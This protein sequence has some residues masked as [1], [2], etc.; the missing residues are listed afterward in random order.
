MERLHRP[1]CQPLLDIG[2]AL[3]G[4]PMLII[5][6]HGRIFEHLLPLIALQEEQGK[7]Y[8]RDEED[9]IDGHIGVDAKCCRRVYFD[10]GNP[11][12]TY[13]DATVEPPLITSI[14]HAKG[15]K[16]V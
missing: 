1:C 8:V 10:D 5:R 13:C 3:P 16:P 15:L 9:G 7:R 14:V 11:K 6:T 4:F 2:Q 12:V